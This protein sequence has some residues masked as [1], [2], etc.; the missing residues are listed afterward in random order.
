MLL[1]PF[2]T[3]APDLLEWLKEFLGHPELPPAPAP[4][5]QFEPIESVSSSSQEKLSE[6]QV[7]EVG[8]NNE[9]FY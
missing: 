7:L 5:K 8:K 6:E 4:T 9:L 3:K 1:T 2:L